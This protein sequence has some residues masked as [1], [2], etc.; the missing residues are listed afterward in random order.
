MCCVTFI[1]ISYVLTSLAQQSSSIPT[2]FAT[3]LRNKILQFYRKESNSSA[4]MAR[5]LNDL[6]NTKYIDQKDSLPQRIGRV[7]YGVI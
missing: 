3:R 5:L 7:K 4:W 1:R 2:M 6:I